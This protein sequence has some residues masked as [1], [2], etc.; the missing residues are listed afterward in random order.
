[1]ILASC[2]YLAETCIGE[3]VKNKCLQTE[4]DFRLTDDGSQDQQ[5]CAKECQQKKINP[6]LL[7]LLLL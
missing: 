5:I 1:M 2:P 4:P 3:S 6:T 7:L